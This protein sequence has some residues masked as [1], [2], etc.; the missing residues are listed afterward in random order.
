[1]QRVNTWLAPLGSESGSVVRNVC[2]CLGIT[3][4][5]W[6]SIINT[7]GERLEEVRCKRKIKKKV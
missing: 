4:T 7:H 1:M 6:W 2:G 3:S 5:L